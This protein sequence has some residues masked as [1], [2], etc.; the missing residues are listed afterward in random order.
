MSSELLPYL[1]PESGAQA[2]GRRKPRA[3]QDG[4]KGTNT[5]LDQF[6]QKSTDG[7][8]Q[9]GDDEDQPAT[10][11]VIMEDGTMVSVPAE[12]PS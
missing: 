1:E 3:E 11:V 8:K 12:A 6:V 4:G 10:K 7:D 5:L 2:P 9:E